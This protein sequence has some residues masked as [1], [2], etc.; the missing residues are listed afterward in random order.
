MKL[1]TIEANGVTYAE[2]RDGHPVYVHDDGKEIAFDAPHAVATIKRVSDERDT[3]RRGEERYKAFGDLDPEK[4][5]KALE[6]VRNLD[7]KKLL[8]AGKVDEIVKERLTE[9][10]K[11]H[12]EQ[13]AA[14][15]KA[16]EESD[17]KVRRLIVGNGFA[18]SKFLAEQTLLPPSVAERAFGDYFR[19]EGDRAVG[20]IGDGKVYSRK[21]P[22]EVADFDEALQIVIEASPDRDRILR[23]SSSNG[24]NATGSTA[25]PPSPDFN[26][27]PAEERLA[28]G[29]SSAARSAA[30]N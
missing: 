14:E 6:I 10:A 28:R 17:A 30:P 25:K 27:L 12:A 26:N 5:R 18:T 20:Y 7:D 13:I 15:K 29:L 9:A 19:V 11:V 23:G 1:K 8:D 4:A 3:L 2:V 22:G 24:S 16:R 21:R